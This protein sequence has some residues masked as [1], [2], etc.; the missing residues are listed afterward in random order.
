[1][2]ASV[3]N[4]SQGRKPEGFICLHVDDLY[5]AGSPEFEKRV[6]AKIRK[7][8]NAVGSEDKNDIM[9]VGQQIKWKNHE[10]FGNY[11]SCDQKLAVD[12]LEEIKV[13]KHMKDYMPCLP[14]M[15]TAYG[16]ILGQLNWLQSRTQCHIRYRFSRCASAAAKPTIADAREINK[17]VR[18]LKSLVGMPDASY[19]N[20]ADK[21]S[22]REHVLFIAEDRKIG[23]QGHKGEHK[24]NTRGSVV[25]YESH[26]ITTKLNLLLLQ[27]IM[28]L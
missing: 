8:F 15:H 13:E 25:D 7:D 14:S 12:Q 4:N 23:R 24:V 6:L 18:T 20:N 9:F 22:Q 3:R 28:H 26:K 21:S 5:M 19:R 1:M 10:K 11:F 16:S 17:T 2:N 27:N